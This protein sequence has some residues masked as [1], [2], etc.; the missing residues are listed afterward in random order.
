[1]RILS[2]VLNTNGHYVQVSGCAE[3][4]SFLFQ[5]Y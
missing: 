5:I 4:P 2:K 3:T 1:M